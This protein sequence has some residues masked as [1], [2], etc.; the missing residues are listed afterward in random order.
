MLSRILVCFAFL[1]CDHEVAVNRVAE[2]EH[3]LKSESAKSKQLLDPAEQRE[4]DLMQGEKI[5]VARLLSLAAH[6]GGKLSTFS[7]SLPI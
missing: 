2:L 1:P 6:V 5:E 7:I 4:I 3:T